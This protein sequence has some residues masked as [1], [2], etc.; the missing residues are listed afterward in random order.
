MQ[1]EG[2]AR[3]LDGLNY[4]LI[5]WEGWNQNLTIVPTPELRSSG[6]SKTPL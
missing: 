5:A 2:G 6:R 3:I 1:Q 4:R